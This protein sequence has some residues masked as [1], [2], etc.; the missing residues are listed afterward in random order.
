MRTS[1]HLSGWKAK[2][3]RGLECL[4]CQTLQEEHHVQQRSSTDVLWHDFHIQMAHFSMLE[5]M[6]RQIYSS[7]QNNILISYNGSWLLRVCLPLFF[8]NYWKLINWAMNRTK[9]NIYAWINSYFTSIKINR[10]WISY[11][12]EALH[13]NVQY[14]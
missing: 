3:L 9:Q 4:P 13:S 5:E 2:S 6:L 8:L 11:K 12:A 7:C 10:H 14:I 1:S